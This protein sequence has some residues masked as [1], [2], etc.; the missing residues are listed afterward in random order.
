MFSFIFKIIFIL[1]IGHIF[2]SALYIVQLRHENRLLFLELQTLQQQRDRLNVKWGQLQLEQSTLTQHHR[3]ETIAREK[4]KMRMP[5][6]SDIVLIK[7]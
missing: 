3:I 4:M 5:D 2:I 6:P 7:P 1:L